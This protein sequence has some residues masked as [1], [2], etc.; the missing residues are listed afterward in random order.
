MMDDC[1]GVLLGA[2]IAADHQW[3]F[4]AG[5]TVPEKFQKAVI[6]FED[7]FFY[8]H[9]GLN[10]WAMARAAYQDIKAGKIVSGGSTI[11]M[12]VIRL[13]RKGRPRTVFEKIAEAFLAVRLELTYSKEEILALYAANAPFGGN[14]VGIDAASWRYFGKNAAQLSWAEAATLAV[15]PNSPAL[16]Y[17]G[18]SHDKL[19]KKRNKILNKLYKNNYIS[20]EEF[21]LAQNEPLPGKPYPLPQAAT[22][23]LDRSIKEGYSGKRIKTTLDI[24]LQTRVLSIIERYHEKYSANK[25]NNAA[26]LVVEVET[27]N[28]LAYVGN[29]TETNHDGNG[30]QVD[31]ITSPRSTG[32]ILKPF[33]YAAMINDG[34]LLPAALVP[35]IPVQLGGF[36]PE[37]YSLTY[38]GAVPAKR[39]LSR[40]LNVPAV[41]MLQAYGINRFN[42]VL[43]K[44][45]LTT[46]HKPP[47]HYGLA[48]IL[49]GA[50]ANLWDMTGAYASM[51]RTLNHYQPYDS[52]YDK[53]DFRPPVYIFQDAKKKSPGTE[54]SSVLS[55]SS[56][57]F[58]FEAMNEVSRPDEDMEWQQFSSSAKIAWKTGTSYGSRDAWAI[59]VNPRYVVAVWTGNSDGEG[60]PGMTG[61]TYAAPIM[62]EVFKSLK[63][64]GWFYAPYDDMIRL[65]VCRHSGFKATAVCEEVDTVWVQKNGAKSPNC[66]YH[67]I[68]KLDASG[69]WRVNS[70]CEPV[71][72]IRF[73]KWFVL[74]PVMEYFYKSKNPFYRVLPPFRDDCVPQESGAGPDM[75]YPKNNSRIYIPV[76][77]NGEREKVVF[78]AA[79]NITGIKLH[80][81]L[82]N[83][84]IGSTSDFHQMALAPEAGKHKLTLVD[85][86]GQHLTVNFEIIEKQRQNKP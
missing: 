74:P 64:E 20:Q 2:R 76:D 42:Y 34:Q 78:K 60:R 86:K 24:G 33:L 5:K 81:Y 49:G 84:F 58:T 25:V 63:P 16:I 44:I 38:D 23:L 85:Q 46:L 30:C 77:L 45:G 28:V 55:A 82:D 39:A 56:I 51:A 22:H 75:I 1:Q 70:E 48:I 41:K 36:I 80:W 4:P 79:H 17:P 43:K 71:A 32:S 35:D 15:L 19:L 52:R 47:S 8:Y 18:K 11:T 68:I 29:T 40:S 83:T 21:L 31:I 37:N 61:L 72:A 26:V 59:G 6:M 57:W 62:F 13:S 67:Q 9:N 50:E 12:Q 7:R 54:K 66:P 69:R 10:P 27:G 65:P 3:R 53:G 14:V 73:Q